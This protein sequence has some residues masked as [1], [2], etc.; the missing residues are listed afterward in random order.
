MSQYHPS[1]YEEVP[2]YDHSKN[3]PK[4]RETNETL[5]EIYSI[6]ITIDQVE[7]AYLK[8]LISSKEYTKSLNK[9]LL[10]YKT[11]LSNGNEDVKKEFE[12]L[13]KFKDK[14]NII[15]SNGVTRIERGMPVTVEHAIVTENEA[16]NNNTGDNNASGATLKNGKNIA[17]A[18][19][20]FITIMDAI[21]L[22]FRAKDQLHPLMSELLLSINK[23]TRSNFEH[24][25]QL[26][27]WIVKINKMKINDKLTE[28]EARE[29]LFD[30]DMAYKSFYTTLG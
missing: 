25:S 1:L 17:E 2:F 3:D 19:G 28:D 15:A 29:L 23:V 11:F 21:K 18:T 8:D 20:N 4:E 12:D 16:E 26:V 30:I 27:E 24:R 22:N 9:L 10:Q 14:Y 5:A 7:K 6:I 13:Y